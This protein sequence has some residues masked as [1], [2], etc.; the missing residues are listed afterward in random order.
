MYYSNSIL[1]SVSCLYTGTY[2]ISFD[3]RHSNIA[4]CCPHRGRDSHCGGMLKL[5]VALSSIIIYM[6]GERERLYMHNTAYTG[7]LIQCSIYVLHDSPFAES[8]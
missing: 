4:S 7:T 6:E 3:D 5:K 1:D 2:C 8:A